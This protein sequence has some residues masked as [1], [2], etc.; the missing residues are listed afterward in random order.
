MSDKKNR[1][2]HHCDHNDSFIPWPQVSNNPIRPG[3]TGPSGET[4]PPGETGPSGQT[5]P[6]GAT[7]P[8]G[9]LGATGPNEI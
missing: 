1:K 9:P 4:G 3:P 8:T 6:F 2:T 7:G 5:G